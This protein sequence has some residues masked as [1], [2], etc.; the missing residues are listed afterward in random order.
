MWKQSA[1][2]VFAANFELVLH[3]CP[4]CTIGKSG[5]VDRIRTSTQA[6]AEC[7]DVLP[8]GLLVD[9]LELALCQ[10]FRKGPRSPV[11]TISI[12]TTWSRVSQVKFPTQCPTKSDFGKLMQ[13]MVK[14][15]KFGAS[16]K[17]S[18][19]KSHT[20][21]P[22]SRASH[23]WLQFSSRPKQTLKEKLNGAR[24]RCWGNQ[25]KAN[26]SVGSPQVC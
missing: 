21:F 12:L 10:G 19:V 17:G 13:G 7:L 3:V 1:S 2:P 16:T 26:L 9:E 15:R 18:Q 24:T 23:K 11:K 22:T 20:Q 25:K 4:K 8:V 14:V 5:L 6:L